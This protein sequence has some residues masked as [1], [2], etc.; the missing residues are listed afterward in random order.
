VLLEK[1]TG[2]MVS[3][4]EQLAELATQKGL[5]LFVTWHLRYAV[6]VDKAKHLLIDQTIRSVSV[7]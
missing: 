1:P 6:A 3:Q 4:V 5:S 7:V 2:A